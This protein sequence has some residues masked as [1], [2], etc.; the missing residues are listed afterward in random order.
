[1]VHAPSALLSKPPLA[2]LQTLEVGAV[3]YTL[4]ARLCQD[5]QKEL[6]SGQ[7]ISDC[8]VPSVIVDAEYFHPIVQCFRHRRVAGKYR[9][10][11]ER[12]VEPDVVRFNTNR[13]DRGPFDHRAIEIGMKA[14]ER[15]LSCEK[16]E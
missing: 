15:A 9:R 4:L 2:L 11:Q 13:C 1:M 3:F 10:R 6:G 12:Q 5:Y 7:S 16:Q 14:N 8:V